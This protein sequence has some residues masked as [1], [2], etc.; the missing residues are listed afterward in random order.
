MNPLLR[1]KSA[2]E[3]PTVMRD[4]IRAADWEAERVISHHTV[5]LIPRG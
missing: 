3:S 1:L 5:Y 4:K 2:T